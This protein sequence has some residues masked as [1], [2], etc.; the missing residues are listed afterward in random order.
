MRNP[1]TPTLGKV[2]PPYMAGR[3][4]ILEEMGKAFDNGSGNPNL[5]SI[6][7]GPRGS[8]KTALL[9]CIAAKALEHGW[10]SARVP[11]LPGMLED[12]LERT[13]ENAS[14][15]IV[16]SAGML[17]KGIGIPQVLEIEFTQAEANRGNW[18]TRMNRL[19]D[20]LSEHEVGLLITATYVR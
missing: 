15:F 4:D 3:Q 6:I 2:P 9:A 5:S 1:F 10:V 14:E 17:L 8:G 12:I 18:R 7:T 13:R 20:A 16:P 19:L 11:A